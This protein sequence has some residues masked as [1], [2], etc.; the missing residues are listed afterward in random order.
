MP[1]ISKGAQ[2]RPWGI[3]IFLLDNEGFFSMPA[4]SKG[5]QLRP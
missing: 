3:L 4:I 1:A 5:A 2:L